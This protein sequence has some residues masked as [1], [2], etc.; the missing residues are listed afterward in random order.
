MGSQV[1]Q[2]LRD[3]TPKRARSFANRRV[4][5]MKHLLM[6][7]AYIYGDVDQTVVDT[8]DDLTQGLIELEMFLDESLA[9]GRTL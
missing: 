4:N 9:E 6:E 8:C 1:I 7:I 5:K 2:G 3:W